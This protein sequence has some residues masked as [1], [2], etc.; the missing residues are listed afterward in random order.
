T[1]IQANDLLGRKTARDGGALARALCAR[2]A[3]TEQELAARG[4]EDCAAMR[5]G[6]Q[7]A[8]LALEAVVD[9]V[10]SRAKTEVKAVHAGAVNYLRLAGLVLGGWQMARAQLAALERRAEDP[11]FHE[12]KLI[13][14]RFYAEALLPQA[15]ALAASVLAAGSTIERMR[16]ELF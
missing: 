2:I 6:L 5:A 11:D 3:A 13:T 9:F 10:A 1:A 16:P 15:E 12:A 7:R 4:S 8:R 14:A